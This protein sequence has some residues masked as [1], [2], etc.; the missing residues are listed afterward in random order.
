M[1]KS[2]FILNNRQKTF[3]MGIKLFLLVLLLILPCVSYGAIN[4]DGLINEGEWEDAQSFKDFVVV[5]PWNLALPRVSTETKVLSLSEGLAVAF[6]CDQPP[7]EIRT[8]TTTR[9]DASSFDSDY[10]S[11]MIDFDGTHQVGY[12]FSVSITGSYRDGVITDESKLNYD[13]DGIWQRA[14]NEEPRRWTV[15]ILLPWSIVAMREGNGNTRQV[16]ACFQRVLNARNEKFAYPA[17]GT[18]RN[19]FMSDFA[20][21]EVAKHSDVQFDIL[22]YATV[23]S[24]LVNDKTKGK[25][26]LDIFWKPGGKFQLT[27]TANPDFGQV[28]SDDLVINFSATET[29]LSE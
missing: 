16:A 1:S 29:F 11:L 27:A 20:K 17:A 21:I 14:V 23:L 24:D 8:R 3:G 4:V 7:E 5:D 22:P 28:E 18:T 25:A 12:E 15:E 2:I 10:V 19:T 9:R 6:I 26:G 13:W